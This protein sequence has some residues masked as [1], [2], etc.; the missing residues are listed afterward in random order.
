MNYKVYK[1]V[2]KNG[3]EPKDIDDMIFGKGDTVPS[4][5]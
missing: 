5:R 4:E 2:L 1:I 3:D